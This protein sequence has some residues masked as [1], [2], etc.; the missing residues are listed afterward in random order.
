MS[1]MFDQ[2]DTVEDVVRQGRCT[3]YVGGLAKEVNQDILHDAF[4]TFGDIVGVQLPIDPAIKNHR[5][6]G[7]VEFEEEN[8]VQHAIDNMDGAELEGRTLRVNMAKQIQ[9]K[10]NPNAPVWSNSDD[11][12]ASLRK[13][14]IQ[15][16]LEENN[17]V[18][19]S[20]AKARG[21][22]GSNVGPK[23]IPKELPY[24]AYFKT[25]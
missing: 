9:N 12:V 10:E 2:E 19:D 14:K 6:F 21:K 4:I 7:F 1:A 22:A 11:Y 24:K 13:Q 15:E 18:Q 23:Q 16:Q 3:I 17:I 5:G 20:I 8:D 25:S